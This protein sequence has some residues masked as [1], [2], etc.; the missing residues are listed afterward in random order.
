MC[1][2]HH[3]TTDVVKELLKADAD[4]HL[5]DYEGDTALTLA[6]LMGRTDVVKLL[7]DAQAPVGFQDNNGRIALTKASSGSIK[8]S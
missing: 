5:S 3:G 4:V 6:S 8:R 2:S 7:L 1:A